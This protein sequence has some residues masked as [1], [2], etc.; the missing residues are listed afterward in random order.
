MSSTNGTR[1]GRP[2]GAGP[3]QKYLKPLLDGK[4]KKLITHALPNYRAAFNRAVSFRQS[5]KL[6][7]RRVSVRIR[8][9]NRLLITLSDEKGGE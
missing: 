9:D 3:L 8:D 2:P 6:M 7:G 5:A 1:R 4:R